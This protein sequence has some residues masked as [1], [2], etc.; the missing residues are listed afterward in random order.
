MQTTAESVSGDQRLQD[1]W[2][3]RVIAAVVD[4]I[5]TAVIALIA[6]VP[7]FIMSQIPIVGV[8]S[9]IAASFI[10]G[11]VYVF[12]SAWMES[13]SGATVGK[14]MMRLHVVAISGQM[15]LERA[16][17][18]NLSK[19]HF[20]ALIIDLL[21][22]FLTEG[23]PRQ[24]YLDRVAGTTVVFADPPQAVPYT[25]QPPPP[26]QY[27][28]PQAGAP[29]AQPPRARQECAECGGRLIEGGDGRRQCIRC[30]KVF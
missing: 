7:L 10:W 30:G 13:N 21:V 9:G 18:R 27:A 3:S 15:S 17:K 11:I 24:R 6:W 28:P 23:D 4:G 26:P 19:I 25:P 14:R 16:L 2:V 29:S 22:G 1:H 5:I 12:Y 8:I 20:L